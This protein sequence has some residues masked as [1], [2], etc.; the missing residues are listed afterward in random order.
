M[1]KEGRKDGVSLSGYVDGLSGRQEPQDT[2]STKVY[3]A[4]NIPPST[5]LGTRV[6][7]KDETCLHRRTPQTGRRWSDILVPLPC[8]NTT[9]G[10]LPSALVRDGAGKNNLR[11]KVVGQVE[12]F[13]ADK[14]L[15]DLGG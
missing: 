15:G 4:P 12:A 1:G 11:V 3:G 6:T 14:Q 2:H 7:N 5:N 8:G 9:E 10:P 13:Q